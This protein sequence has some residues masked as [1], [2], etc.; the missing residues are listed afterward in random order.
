MSN[1]FEVD[2]KGLAR[3]LARRSKAFVVAELLQNAWDEA[4]VST[5]AMSLTRAPG[6]RQVTLE[7]TDDSAKG[8]EDLSQAFTLFAPSKK[9]SDPMARGRFCLGE[10]LTLSLATSAT[11][12]S[13]A[14]GWAFTSEG[15]KPIRERRARGTCVR[16]TLPMTRDDV[17]EC[18]ALVRRLLPPAHIRTTFNG[19]ALERRTV[20]FTTEQTLRTEIADAEGNLRPTKRRTRVDLV[21][22]EEDE[23]GWLYEMGI[24]VVATGDAFHVDVGQKVPLNMERD[25]VPPAYLRAIRVLMLNLTHGEIDAE[26][27][28]ETWA[29]EALGDPNVSTDAVQSSFHARFG[30]RAVIFD[31]SDPEANKIAAS[32][33]YTVIHGS[34]MGGAEWANVRRA[35]LVQPAGQVTPSAK[36]Y[37]EDGAP[38]KLIPVERWTAA[39]QAFA[40]FVRGVAR[41]VL[42]GAEVQVRYANEFG[43]PFS[44]T[45]S[46]D[47]MTF[48]LGSLGL[49]FPNHG[50]TEQSVKLVVHELGHHYSSDHLSAKY[51]DALTL[52][53]ARLALASARNPGLMDI[54]S[55]RKPAAA[56]EAA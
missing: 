18:E 37:S 27:S 38:I 8:F 43:W 20:A 51:Y 14:G 35:N 25:G 36:P 45:Y 41:E 3:L 2:R 1:W 48:N 16:I 54:S 56:L 19:A 39:M 46:P 40:A 50:V 6:D 28:N 26:R 49:S 33:G 53:A 7:V 29:R 52:I 31:P 4:G 30:D 22:L 5:V 10:K 44:A 42:E 47:C 9:L 15:R 17:G 21:R 34:Q 11:I 55:Y 24:P 13:T 12:V 23:E 32:K